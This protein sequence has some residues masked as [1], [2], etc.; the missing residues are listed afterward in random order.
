[1]SVRDRD[2]PKLLHHPAIG[3]AVDGYRVR[4]PRRCCGWAAPESGLRCRAGQVAADFRHVALRNLAMSKCAVTRLG[5]MAWF[6]SRSAV[7][8]S[9]CDPATLAFCQLWLRVRC[10][11]LL[12]KDSETGGQKSASKTSRKRIRAKGPSGSDLLEARLLSTSR[13]IFD[14]RRRPEFPSTPRTRF[15]SRVAV[16][17]WGNGRGE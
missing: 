11:P 5:E 15:S 10:A 3:T 6:A 14:S 1:M 9:A 7:Y 13:A 2:R 12:D 16:A 4:V 8:S 17:A